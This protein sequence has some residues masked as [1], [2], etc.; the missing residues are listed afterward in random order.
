MPFVGQGTDIA[1]ADDVFFS[2]PANDNLIKYNGA[3]SKWN[4]VPLAGLATTNVIADN[5][6]TEPKL[7]ASNTPSANQVLGWNGTAFTW[8]SNGEPS[9]VAGTTSQYYRGDKTWQTLDKSTVGLSNVENT[10]DL[11]KPVSTATQTALNGRALTTT[12]ITGANSV[13]GGGTLAADRTLSLVGDADAPGNSKYYGTNATGQKGFHTIPSGDPTLAGD[14]TGTASNAQIAASAVGTDELANLAVT[15]AKMADNTITEPKLSVSNNPANGQMLTWNG[16]ALTWATPQAFSYTRVDVSTA[17]YTASPFQY[18]FAD[19]ASTGI[20]ITLPAPQV[21][22]YV[23]VKRI[24]GGSNGVQVIA[25]SGSYIDATSVGSD[26]L[27][28]PYQS[29][30]YWSDGANWYR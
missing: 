17:T 18:V 5:A 30:E 2:V 8:V 6:V 21:N 20:T 23:R 14:L 3:T 9:I 10:T 12:T 29:Q 16:T 22:S 26:A 19:P 15:G 4:N 1:H 11:G 28:V 24:T 27:N 25:P 13:T 7:A